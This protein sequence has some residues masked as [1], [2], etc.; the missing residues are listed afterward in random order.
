ML[1]AAEEHLC[2]GSAGT[3]NLMQPDLASRL[4]NRNAVNLEDT[5]AEVIA[6]GN[7]GCLVQIAGI[8][9][10]PVVHTVELLDWATGGPM[11]VELT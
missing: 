7:I 8:A 10:I 4:G 5:G 6:T 9:K 2:C 11:P 1:E 3:Y